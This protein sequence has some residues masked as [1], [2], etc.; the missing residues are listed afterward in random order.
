MIDI[1]LKEFTV[2]YGLSL[3]LDKLRVGMT[4]RGVVKSHGNN[5]A[6]V[7]IKKSRFIGRLSFKD[8]FEEEEEYKEKEAEDVITGLTAPSLFPTLCTNWV[9]YSSKLFI[10]ISL[11]NYNKL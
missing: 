2:K 6:F 9:Q 11:I 7:Y 10:I 4:I 1:S 3:T 5:S 8:H